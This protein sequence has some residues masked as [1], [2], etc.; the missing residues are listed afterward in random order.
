MFLN[1]VD[2]LGFIDENIVNNTGL[3]GLILRGLKGFH[4]EKSI[5]SVHRRRNVTIFLFVV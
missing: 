4:F 3:T 5:L 1:I 2:F